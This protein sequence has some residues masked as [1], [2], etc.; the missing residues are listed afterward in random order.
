MKI[1]AI[2]IKAAFLMI[3]FSLNTLIG[4]GCAVGLDKIFTSSHHEEEV[5]ATK[6]HI[7]ADGEKHNYNKIE[8]TEAKVHVH[9]N[10][11]KHIHEE[12]NKKH[13]SDAKQGTVDNNDAQ[14]EE[15]A[16][17]CC[18]SKVTKYEQLDKSVPQPLKVIPV[19]FSGNISEFYN[20]E[21]LYTSHINTSIR[22]FVRSYHPP[23]PNIRIA[24]QSFQ[25]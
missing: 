15:S 4:F 25:I 7:H 9:A 19:V 1:K 5:T 11:K 13:S 17:N 8:G 3:V 18:T 23:L 24:I 16:D 14:S 12:K 10:G 21:V 20:I 6:V 22:Y 2:Q